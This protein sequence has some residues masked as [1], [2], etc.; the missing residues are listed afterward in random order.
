MHTTNH[1][2][3]GASSPLPPGSDRVAGWTRSPLGLLV[4]PRPRRRYELPVAVELFAGAGGFGC[5]LHQAGFHVAAAVEMDLIAAT[6]YMVN[7]AVPGVKVHFDGPERE[8]A[9]E[10]HLAKAMGLK[11]DGDGNLVAP[12]GYVHRGPLAGSGWISG[13]GRPHDPGSYPNDYL[14]DTNR[15]PAHPYGCEQFF[16]ADVRNLTGAQVLDALGLDVGD[17]ALV[18][19]GPPCQ[20]FSMAGARDVMDP[21]NSLVFEFARL[22]CEIRPR[23]F[24]MENVPGLAS[25]VTPEGIPV[26]DAFS[27]ALDDGGYGEYEALR[28]SLGITPG[29]RAGVRGAKR[30]RHAS[31]DGAEPTHGSPDEEQQLDLFGPDL[32]VR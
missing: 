14:A 7:L 8:E 24:V 4:P 10:R 25:M 28:R 19:G 6:T 22:I 11:L 5:G 20:G 30:V 27:K 26:V 1:R 23:A 2:G 16:V 13:Y 31:P 32:A 15:P 9:F 18:T 3:P 12:E 17:V 21:R 29:V